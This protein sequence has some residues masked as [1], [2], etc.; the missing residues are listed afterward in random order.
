[1]KQS[2]KD[3]EAIGN[4]VV[5][6]SHIED[7]ALRLFDFADKEDRAASFHRCVDNIAQYIM[8]SI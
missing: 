1:M 6:Q 5:A 2:L 8:Y 4:D 7:V 3:D